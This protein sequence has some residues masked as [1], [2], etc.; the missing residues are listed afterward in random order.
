MVVPRI[1]VNFSTHELGNDALIRHWLGLFSSYG[2]TCD[3]LEI[4]LTES[5]FTDDE[6]AL[7]RRLGLLRKGWEV[8][9]RWMILA[10]VTPHW[11]G[12]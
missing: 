3:S 11:D 4:E 9:W 5:A 12:W 6:S 7:S 8:P 2:F 1:S 10:P